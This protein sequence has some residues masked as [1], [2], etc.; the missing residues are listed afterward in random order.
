MDRQAWHAAVHGVTKSQTWLSDWT[1]IY[2]WGFTQLQ[3]CPYL[4][5]L[6]L[7]EHRQAQAPSAWPLSLSDLT[8]L[9]FD[10]IISL[11]LSRCSG[12]ILFI[13]W[14]WM[15]TSHFCKK[16]WPLES[17]KGTSEPKYGCSVGHRPQSVVLRVFTWLK[18]LYET[19]VFILRC[20][21]PFFYFCACLMVVCLHPRGKWLISLVHMPSDQK[22]AHPSKS[23][24]TWRFLGDA[25][26]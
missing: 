1:E 12:L 17:G 18:S 11:D 4:L 21:W 5:K 3:I 23:F 26:L 10:I 9:V 2:L 7:A 13:P 6:K 20:L 24:C 19:W 16:L 15:R 8:L 14:P 25:L 22:E